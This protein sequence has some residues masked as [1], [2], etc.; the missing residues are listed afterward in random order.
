MDEYERE[1]Y[2]ELIVAAAPTAE[3]IAAGVQ[4]TQE[5]MP[6]VVLPNLSTAELVAVA[7]DLHAREN[8]DDPYRD[9]LISWLMMRSD[10]ESS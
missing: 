1:W 3:A 6:C 2:F 10:E 8:R 9:V 5:N 4:P 7:T